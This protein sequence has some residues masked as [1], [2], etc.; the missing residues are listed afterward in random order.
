MR[1][2]G[3]GRGRGDRRAKQR[4]VRASACSAGEG[5]AATT[6]RGD[7]GGGG[8]SGEREV[9]DV[10][11]GGVESDGEEGVGGSDRSEGGDADAEAANQQLFFG[12]AAVDSS[13]SKPADKEISSDM[14]NNRDHVAT[15]L[16]LV[17]L[18]SGSESQ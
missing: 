7:D 10:G 13:R 5:H 18:V 17:I 2:G 9:R 15:I 3:S 6:D 16:L 12:A 11:E 4:Q 8:D 1:C 14:T